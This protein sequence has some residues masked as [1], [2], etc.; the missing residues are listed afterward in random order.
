MPDG[1]VFVVGPCG[2]GKSTLLAHLVADATAARQ[3]VCAARVIA[4]GVLVSGSLAGPLRPDAMAGSMSD[5]GGEQVLSLAEAVDVIVTAVAPAVVVLDDAH[6]LP[7]CPETQ[8]EVARLIRLLPA[9]VRV[10]VATTQL[11]PQVLARFDNALAG[12]MSSVDLAF[13][14]YEVDRL[15]REVHHVPLR[16]ADVHAL[17]RA[18]EGWAAALELFRV[19]TGDLLPGDRSRAIRAMV[20]Q[21]WFIADYAERVILAGCSPAQRSLLAWGSVFE[22][23]TPGRLAALRPDT[24]GESYDEQLRGLLRLPTLPLERTAC[25]LR[26]PGPLRRYLRATHAR[27][28][29][30]PAAREWYARAGAV[31][32]DDGDTPAALVCYARAGRGEHLRRLAEVSTEELWTQARAVEPWDAAM[33]EAVTA[34]ATRFAG[35]SRAVA[36]GALTTAATLADL[37]VAAAAPAPDARTIRL[38]EALETWGGA[39]VPATEPGPG[40]EWRTRLRHLLRGTALPLPSTLGDWVAVGLV[41]ALTQERERARSELHRVIEDPGAARGLALVATLA[42]LLLDTDLAPDRLL[43]GLDR[44][45]VEAHA[46]GLRWLERLAHAAVLAVEGAAGW[47]EAV[48]RL[49]RWG[50]EVGDMWGPL[51]VSSVAELCAIR[52]DEDDPQR[53]LELAS[54]WQERGVLLAAEACRLAAVRPTARRAFVPDIAQEWADPRGRDLDSADNGEEEAAFGMARPNGPVLRLV[55]TTDQ[56][57]QGVDTA[58]QELRLVGTAGQELRLRCLGEFEVQVAG[59]VVDLTG[60][61]PRARSLL[62]FLALETGR[63]VHRERLLEALWAELPESAAMHNLHTSISAVRRVLNL[64]QPG[65]GRRVLQ[66][67]GESYVLR[68]QDVSSDLLD[69]ETALRSGAEAASAGESERERRAWR[70][71][72]SEYHEDLLIEEGSAEWV[73]A[74]RERLRQLVAGAATSLAAVQLR[75]GDA[76]GAVEAASRALELDEWRDPAWRLLIQALSQS[77]QSARAQRV[78]QSYR[79]MLRSLGLEARAGNATRDPRGGSATGMRAR[80]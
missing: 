21:P 40:T 58:D 77:G 44:V 45:L 66:R 36:D 42:D 37:L 47:R 33:L 19:G 49:R 31:L 10:V 56:E 64:A 26:L 24:A 54:S 29:G 35:L 43:D 17:S 18:T 69:L 20:T 48:A 28:L 53:W 12:V 3:S 51:T 76:A 2:S 75:S 68:T 14:P 34:R 1:V 60:L 50:H 6:L 46:L 78:R 38:R 62:R 11:P 9:G 32:E 55:G 57:R 16:A 5:P 71:V 52:R 4:R 27:D 79:E 74:P 22:D 63:P 59:K 39:R 25:G 13:R 72:L 7:D 67:D 70:R 65:L 41:H 80:I 8:E 30:R 61:R 73:L 15:F 23:M